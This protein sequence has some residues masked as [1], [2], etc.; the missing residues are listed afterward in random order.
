MKKTFLIITF[1]ASA[2]VLS[3]GIA[4]WL[5]QGP[6]DSEG[7]SFGQTVRNLLNIKTEGKKLEKNTGTTFDEVVIKNIVVNEKA[8]KATLPLHGNNGHLMLDTL[9][10]SKEGFLISVQEVVIGGLEKEEIY[11]GLGDVIIPTPPGSRYVKGRRPPMGRPD[12]WPEG[13]IPYMVDA[14][15]KVKSQLYEVLKNL[16]EQT[17]IRFVPKRDE[18]DYVVIRAHEKYCLSNVGKIGGEQTI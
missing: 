7:Q 1:L 4:R 9:E 14:N 8:L 16:N 17:G 15:L 10:N 6:Q 2:I 5:T 12:L 18:K 13:R 11:V 3:F